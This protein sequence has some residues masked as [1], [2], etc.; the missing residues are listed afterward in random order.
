M[1]LNHTQRH[2][3]ST[4]ERPER[5]PV[6]GRLARELCVSFV[7]NASLGQSLTEMQV[8]HESVPNHPERR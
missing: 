4:K 5:A 1:R 7:V 8:L 2:E 3:R 6:F